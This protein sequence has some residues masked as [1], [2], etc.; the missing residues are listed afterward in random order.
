MTARDLIRILIELNPDTPIVLTDDGSIYDVCFSSDMETI[1]DEETKESVS[2]FVLNPCL[3]DHA[4]E[5]IL[6]EMELT[7]KD[8]KIDLN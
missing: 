5:E 7:S 2:V 3:C 8:F 6:D 4:D 1:T